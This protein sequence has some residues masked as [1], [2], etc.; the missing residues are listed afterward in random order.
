MEVNPKRRLCA[1]VLNIAGIILMSA[2]TFV[3]YWVTLSGL[4][5][6]GIGIILWSIEFRK[7][8]YNPDIDD[9]EDIEILYTTRDPNQYLPKEKKE[10]WQEELDVLE[11]E[12]RHKIC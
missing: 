2:G 11:L 6:F 5:I 12:R 8:H 9:D 3:S 7:G 1:L 4:L 10:V